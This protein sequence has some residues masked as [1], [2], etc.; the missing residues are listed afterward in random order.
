MKDMPENTTLTK[1]AIG[2]TAVTAIA[3][4]N[5]SKRAISM[6]LQIKMERGIT[7]KSRNDDQRLLERS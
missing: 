4:T 6:L 1:S 7:V 5:I 3:T 2:V